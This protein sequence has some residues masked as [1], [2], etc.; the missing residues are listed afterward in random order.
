MLRRLQAPRRAVARSLPLPGRESSLAV[1]E[2]AMRVFGSGGTIPMA[3]FR[4][5]AASGQDPDR[6]AGP[7]LAARGTATSG[8]A[9]SGDA[10][11][12]PDAHRDASVQ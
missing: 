8:S 2:P 11:S 3:A 7:A 6:Q 9:V 1:A 5:P 4:D 10:A 12:S